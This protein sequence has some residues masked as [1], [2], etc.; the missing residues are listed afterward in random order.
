MNRCRSCPYLCDAAAASS[1]CAGKFSQVVWASSGGTGVRVTSRCHLF[2]PPLVGRVPCLM[3]G[4]PW[5]RQI[6]LVE[7]AV[8]VVSCL[9]KVDDLRPASNPLDHSPVGS[10]LRGQDVVKIPWRLCG[11]FWKVEQQHA[12]KSYPSGRLTLKIRLGVDG[13][14]SPFSRQYRMTRKN[15]MFNS[16]QPG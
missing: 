1:A 12:A 10:L 7:V 6:G 14:Q 11:A 5:M 2:H 4:S 3:S 16:V 9:L 8:V 13:S 15:K